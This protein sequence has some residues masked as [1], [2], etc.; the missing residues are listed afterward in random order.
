M[1]GLAF[2]SPFK[3]LSQLSGTPAAASR[4]GLRRSW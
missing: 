2:T 3:F 4:L 1:N